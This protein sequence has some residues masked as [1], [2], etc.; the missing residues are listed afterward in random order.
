MLFESQINSFVKISSH[1][2]SPIQMLNTNTGSVLLQ[3]WL[4]AAV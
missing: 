4:P 3:L 2:S 1:L